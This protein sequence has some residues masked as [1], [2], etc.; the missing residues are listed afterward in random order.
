MLVKLCSKSFKLGF[1]SV[2]TEHLQMNKL[3]LQIAE[4][5]EIQLLHSLDHKEA[6]KFQK[7]IYFC[8]TEYKKAFD[9][10]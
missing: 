5:P 7:K 2:C 8:F 1:S 4:E 9:C 3:G 10:W 6:R